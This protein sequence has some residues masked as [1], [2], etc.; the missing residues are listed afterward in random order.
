MTSKK[1]WG[2]RFKQKADPGFW[3]FSNSLACD[4]VLLEYDIKAGIAHAKM[5]SKCNII[6]KDKAGSI[7]KALAAMLKDYQSGKF[8]IDQKAEDVHTAVFIALSKKIGNTADYLHTA[9]SRND[10]VALDTRMYCKDK[11]KQI[12]KLLTELQM[13]LVDFAKANVDIIMPGYT[14]TQHAVPVLASHQ[15][16]AYVNALDRDK[17]R[18][19][20]AYERTDEMPLGGCAMAGTGLAIDRAYV[21]KLLGFSKVSSN[22]ID[23]VSSRD[24]IIEILSCLSILAMNASRICQ[25]LILYSCDDACFLEIDQAYCTGSSIMPQKKN[26]DSLELIRAT[27]A[28]IYA[29]LI[30][31]LA[32]M[33]G[34]P[35]SYNRDMQLDKR[36]LFNSVNN[37]IYCLGILSGI[38][39]TIK[40]NRQKL[41]D[42]LSS[43]DS[44][45]AL[46]IADYLVRKA[47]PFSQA[48]ALIGKIIVYAEKKKKRFSALT[49]DELKKFSNSFNEDVFGLF[50]A[51]RSVMLKK[52]M[53]STNPLLVRQQ[54]D[55]WQKRLREYYASVY[56]QK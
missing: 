18:L 9:R 2:G 20:S 54:I 41:Q 1:L 42:A 46:D 14:H 43:D 31:V 47:M 7:E 51:K 3:A 24:F 29:D 10:Q 17:Q 6:P 22:S 40:I 38:F 33:K 19:E 35:F 8:K 15:I 37:I 5:L 50:D 48:H 23:A 25:D 49:L 53:G 55:K 52:S 21:A 28:T 26:P 12:I 44:I 39:K 56:I 11:L 16:L 45:Y 13:T 27:A 34:L 30:S 32:L 36:P 4:K